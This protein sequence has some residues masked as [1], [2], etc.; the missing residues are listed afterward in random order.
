ME[1]VL[2]ELDATKSVT[3]N[4]YVDESQKNSRYV[5]I[6]GRDVLL[7]RK[8][9]LCFS[10]FTV[11]GNGGGCEGCTVPM[12]DPSELRDDAIF[13]NEELWKIEHLLDSTR[14]TRRILDTQYQKPDLRKIMSNSKH[15][16]NNKKKYVT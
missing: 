11:K 6:I 9:D 10:D 13:R 14:H 8:L 7:E 1:L 16:K 15:F 2:P 4:F 5:M 12:K 3:W